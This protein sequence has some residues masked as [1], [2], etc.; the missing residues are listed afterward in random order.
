MGIVKTSKYDAIDIREVSNVSKNKSTLK[1]VSTHRG[2][3][4]YSIMDLIKFG[5]YI[6][7]EDY[8]YFRVL[9]RTYFCY[10]I[11]DI[12]N[13]GALVAKN[14]IK[15]NCSGVDYANYNKDNR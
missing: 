2:R 7:D 14:Q 3:Y 11:E 9:K 5:Y 1:L 6:K 12:D 4:Y 15:S 10:K 8:I 13:F